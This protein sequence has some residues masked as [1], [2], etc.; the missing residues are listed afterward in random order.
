MRLTE[1]EEEEKYPRAF[2]DNKVI[3]VSKPVNGNPI[4]CISEYERGSLV[5]IPNTEWAWK[6]DISPDKKKV[7]IFLWK[8]FLS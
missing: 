8:L 7:S 6:Y 2:K 4:I 5:K 1:N 3:Y